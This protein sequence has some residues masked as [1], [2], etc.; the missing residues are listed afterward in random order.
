MTQWTVFDTYMEEYENIRR[1][2]EEEN[3]KNKNREKK[4]T[5]VV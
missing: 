1:R 2:E 4:P 3:A 5:Q